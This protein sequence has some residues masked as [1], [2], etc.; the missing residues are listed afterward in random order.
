MPEL[1]EKNWTFQT[2]NVTVPTTTETVAVISPPVTLPLRNHHILVKA[3]AQLT[4]GTGATGIT[5]RIRRGNSVTAPLVGEANLEAVKGAAGSTEPIVIAVAED[6][7]D[8][9]SVQYCLTVQ[10]AAAT[11]NGTVLQALIEVEVL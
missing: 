6:V 2:A 1:Y 4:V 5:A 10:Q 3:W 9:E 8:L 11:G 7:Q